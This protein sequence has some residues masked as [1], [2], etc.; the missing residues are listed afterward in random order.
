MRS[1]PSEQC[2]NI[3]DRTTEKALKCYFCGDWIYAGDDYYS[4][5]N[6]D[7]CEDCLNLHY[8]QTAELADLEFHDIKE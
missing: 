7:C 8:R 2:D 5:D 3:S 4:L 6:I 1:T